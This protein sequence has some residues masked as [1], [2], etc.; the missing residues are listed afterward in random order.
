MK[1][2]VCLV[3]SFSCLA[4]SSGCGLR[5]TLQA[6]KQADADKA[7][8]HAHDVDKGLQDK[9]AASAMSDFQIHRKYFLAMVGDYEGAFVTSPST[10]ADTDPSLPPL[11]GTISVQITLEHDLA[12]FN[13]VETPTV[14]QIHL[15][16]IGSRRSRTNLFLRS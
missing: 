15:H 16:R 6:R 4:A 12:Q 1:K 5:N 10:T 2:F 14:A 13:G 7:A 8:E 3:L 9:D 11:H